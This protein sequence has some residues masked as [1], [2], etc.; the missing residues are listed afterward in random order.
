MCPLTETRPA[1]IRILAW[2]LEQNPSLD[3][4]LARP[5]VAVALWS[6][7]AHFRVDMR[8]PA[9]VIGSPTHRHREFLAEPVMIHQLAILAAVLVDQPRDFDVITAILRDIDQ[10]ALF[11]P[12][13]RLHAFGS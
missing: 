4:A 8:N 7:D 10:L 2:L 9:R 6:R 11:E 12:L 5:V 13:D 3:N 1:A